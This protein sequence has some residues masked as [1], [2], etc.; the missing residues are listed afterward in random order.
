M[1]SLVVCSLKIPPSI[2]VQTVLGPVPADSGERDRAQ[3]IMDRSSEIMDRSSGEHI[4]FCLK[5]Q[6]VKLMVCSI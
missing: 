5:A 3:V 1:F 4:P 2:F 6:D